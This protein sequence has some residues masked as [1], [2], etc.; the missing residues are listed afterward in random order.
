MADHVEDGQSWDEIV[1]LATEVEAAGAT[2]I[3]TGIGWHEARVPTIVTSVPTARSS[4]SAAPLAEHV[5]IPVVASNRINMPRG[6]R[7]DPRRRRRPSWSRWRARCW[8]TRLG[9][10]GRGRRAPTRSTPASPATRRAWTTRSRTRRVSAWSIRAPAT[11]PSWCSQPTRR[12]KRVAV[13]GAGPGRPGRRG[14]R[15]R[16]RPRGRRCSRPRTRSAANST[17]RG[18]FPARRSSPRRSA[19]TRGSSTSTV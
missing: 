10:Q 5:G 1:A 15:R 12:A 4:T 7:A 2:I 11:R 6:R 19:T 16:A 3:N 18:G 14:D 8:P 9:A 13:V 17:W